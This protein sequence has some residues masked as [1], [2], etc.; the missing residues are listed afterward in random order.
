VASRFAE[1]QSPKPSSVARG[2]WSLATLAL[3]SLMS[4]SFAS[5]ALAQSTGG[6]VGGFGG[7][8]GSSSSYRSS[9]TR[10]GSS[11]ST[12]TTPTPTRS[13]A[14]IRQEQERRAAEDASYRVWREARID[15]GSPE[16]D[17]DE[18][19]VVVGRRVFGT[20]ALT[21]GA[22]AFGLAFGGTLLLGWLLWIQFGRT[23]VIRRLSLAVGPEARAEVQ[24]ALR[25]IAAGG[26]RTS[27][28]REKLVGAT[29]EL[30]RR[31]AP[32][33]RYALWS[34][35]R[36]RASPGKR[37]FVELTQSLRERF[38]HETV[39]G[40]AP[41]PHLGASPEE[42][43]GL[44]VVTLL[45]TGAP[46]RSFPTTLDVPAALDAFHARWPL[47]VELI[48]SPAE[49][50][51]RMSSAELETLYPELARLSDD[52]G[53]VTCAFCGALHA[54]ELRTCPACGASTR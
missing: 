21:Q 15:R 24:Q 9:T 5:T 19:A 35:E 38:K 48:W 11:S 17:A 41:V 25:S 27:P 26:A 45:A 43:P 3:A 49:P 36:H 47:G 40:T 30:L 54:K 4:F 2:A 12:T 34:V 13:A 22:L 51:D 28:E 53:R 44:V 33:V 6:R 46:R 7:S 18:R 14:E 37:R 42:G 29:L 39:G 23:F 16:P 50:D 10:Y 31:H 20:D 1:G 52:V 8:S 32:H